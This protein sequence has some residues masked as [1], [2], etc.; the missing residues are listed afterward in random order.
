MNPAALFVFEKERLNVDLTLEQLL[1]S[2]PVVIIA[3]CM[4]EL[5]HGYISYK[6]GDPTPRLTGRLTWNPLKHLDLFGSL[7]LLVF[8]FGWAKPVQVNPYYYK[9]KKRGMILVALAGPVTNFILAFI[10]CLLV[11]LITRIM[12]SSITFETEMG[13]RV[14]LYIIQFLYYFILLNIGLGT[15]NL[16]PF[17]PLDGS[18]VMAAV[19]PEPVY[20]KW[21]QYE[22]YGHF[23]LMVILYLGLLD[24][25]LSFVQDGLYNGM[26]TAADFL[27]GV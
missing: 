18:K 27:I 4:H 23:L 7:C 8:G 16:I 3:I 17:P 19:L 2:V 13:Y 14:F 21:M 15:F 22:R 12:G 6:L 11:S 1:Y 24:T 9:N 25:P 5:A 26:R 10:G 20:M